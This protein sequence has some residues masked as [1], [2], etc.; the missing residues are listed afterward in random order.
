MSMDRLPRWS[1]WITGTL[2]LW[3]VWGVGLGYPL[4]RE[5]AELEVEH[6]ETEAELAA[7]EA[8]MSGV[9][10]IVN[11][12]SKSKCQLDSALHG[13]VTHREIDALLDEL[14]GRGGRSGLSD[15]Q[16]DPELNS[17]LHS[18]A[19]DS[20]APQTEGPLDTV[21][22]SLAAEGGF[23]N[24]GVWLDEIEGRSDF[25]FWTMCRWSARDEDGLTGIEAQAGLVVLKL[26]AAAE[27]RFSADTVE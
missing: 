13:F 10:E 8:R 24:I 4:A 3:M 11:R 20:Q 1:W 27:N 25:R 19:Q 7:V 15:V 21:V 5:I 16:A 17:L 9:P 18:A 6:R 22:I 2:L 23:K 12:L 26:P 14:R